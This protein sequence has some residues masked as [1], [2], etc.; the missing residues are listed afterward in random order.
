M[1]YATADTH[2]ARYSDQD[3]SL[4]VAVFVWTVQNYG[5]EDADVSL[6]FTF[7]SGEGKMEDISYGHYNEPFTCKGIHSEVEHG[8]TLGEG[9]TSKRFYSSFAWYFR[10]LNE[11]KIQVALHSRANVSTLR[12]S[13]LRV[14]L[15]LQHRSIGI[16]Q[17]D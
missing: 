2:I 15:M 11:Y 10:R 9:E 12:F 7:Q 6:M 8:R 4:P 1:N 13:M 5:K 14:E 3:S 16:L 17:F